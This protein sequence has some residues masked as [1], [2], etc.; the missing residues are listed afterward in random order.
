M[1]L[2]CNSGSELEYFMYKKEQIA[3]KQYCG[4]VEFAEIFGIA[5]TETLEGLR[6]EGL[7]GG[8]ARKS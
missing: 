4:F 6:R 5:I 7:F 8:D 1:T 2:A 3:Q